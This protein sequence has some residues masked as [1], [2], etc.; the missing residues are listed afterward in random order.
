MMKRPLQVVLQEENYYP[1]ENP[2]F[3]EPR[4]FADF[5]NHLKVTNT[6][7]DILELEELDVILY[8]CSQYSHD[9]KEAAWNIR[10]ARYDSDTHFDVAKRFYYSLLSDLT[11]PP[12]TKVNAE[13]KAIKSHV[14]RAIEL[15]PKYHDDYQIVLQLNNVTKNWWSKRCAFVAFINA[16]QLLPRSN[17]IDPVIKVKDKKYN[18]AINDRLKSFNLGIEEVIAQ[19]DKTMKF[20]EDADIDDVLDE[21]LSQVKEDLNNG[22]HGVDDDRDLKALHALYSKIC[23]KLQHPLNSRNHFHCDEN[24]TMI[25]MKALQFSLQ[26]WSYPQPDTILLKRVF[27]N[28]RGKG[29]FMDLCREISDSKKTMFIVTGMNGINSE[30]QTE[31]HC[32]AIVTH[33]GEKLIIDSHGYDEDNNVMLFSPAA[34]IYHF[35]YEITEVHCLCLNPKYSLADL[36]DEDGRIPWRT[37]FSR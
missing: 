13:I 19:L 32:C 17:S 7:K 27:D 34:L 16:L 10:T 9:H 31:A 35:P 6:Y 11:I 12:R 33:N 20:A 24:G 14:V 5:V 36:K 8:N 22:H 3:R 18:R 4:M 30:G 21:S 37:I 25:S 15:R 29:K 2:L 23:S 28:L 26:R 1:V